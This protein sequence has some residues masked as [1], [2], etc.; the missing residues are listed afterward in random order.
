M[1]KYP[2]AR[3]NLPQAHGLEAAYNK[4]QVVL[5]AV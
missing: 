4:L 1:K 5:P 3:K 2:N